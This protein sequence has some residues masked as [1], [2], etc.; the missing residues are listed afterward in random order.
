[1]S[2][3]DCNSDRQPEITIWQPKPETLYLWNCNRQRQNS[4]GTSDICDYDELDKS[5]AKSLRQRQT[6]GNCKIGAKTY[7]LPFPFPVIGR[8]RN[9]LATVLPSSP[10]SKM[11][12]F[13]RWNFDAIYHSFRQCSS[14]RGPR[15]PGPLSSTTGPFGCCEK[16]GL[17]GAWFGPPYSSRSLS[18][19]SAVLKCIKSDSL[20]MIIGI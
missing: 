14:Y 11:P 7:I 18:I 16:M 8:C 9:H 4:N 3:S 2:A 1:M 13:C 17:E 10:W 6:A 20:F 19:P 15:G 12:D 5:L